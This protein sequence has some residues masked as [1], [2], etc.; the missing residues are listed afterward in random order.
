MLARH[1]WLVYDPRPACCL[2][3]RMFSAARENKDRTSASLSALQAANLSHATLHRHFLPHHCIIQHHMPHLLKPTLLSGELLKRRIICCFKCG[4][5]WRRFFVLCLQYCR[6]PRP[7]HGKQ[8]TDEA[9]VQP[10]GS[11]ERWSLN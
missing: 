5:Q 8:V 7:G 4:E 10:S 3:E 2:S 6:Q 9:S 11:I 1:A